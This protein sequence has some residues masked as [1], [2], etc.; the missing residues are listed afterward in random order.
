MPDEARLEEQALSEAAE[1]TIG[2][3]LDA[4]ESIDVAVHTDLL[5]MVQGKVESVSIAAQGMVVQKGIRVQEMEL[6]TDSIAINLLRAVFGE[7]TLDQ[8]IEATARLVL[9]EQD[10]NRALN[11]DYMRRKLNKLELNVDGQNVTLEPQGLI[12]H[13]PGGGRMGLGGTLWLHEMGKTRLV[14]F[15][16]VIRLYHIKQPLLLE[17]FQC[18]QGE[19]ISLDFAIALMH[20]FRELLALPYFELQGVALRLNDLEV[21]RGSLTVNTEAYVRELPDLS[22]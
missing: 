1:M 4:V 13:L 17:A 2:A 16:A 10:I 8:P 19:G 14:S 6:H 5:K 15:T 21:Q 11:S 20:K 18:N 22:A 9:T 7:V 3:Q 12:V